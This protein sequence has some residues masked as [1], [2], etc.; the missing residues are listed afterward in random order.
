MGGRGR[1]GVWA[2][3]WVWVCGGGERRPRAHPPTHPPTPTP[4]PCSKHVAFEPRLALRRGWLAPDCR[5]RGQE[6]QLVATVS[7]HGRSKESGHYTA[8]VLQPGG[9]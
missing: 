7:H 8:D 3:G 9:R 4:T 1:G 6:Y 2:G 5:E